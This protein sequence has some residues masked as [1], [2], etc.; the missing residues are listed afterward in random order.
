[1]DAFTLALFSPLIAIPICALIFWL[2]VRRF[3]LNVGKAFDELHWPPVRLVGA[4][5][6]HGIA[7][8]IFFLFYYSSNVAPILV[9]FSVPA[10]LSV[11][12]IVATLMWRI[13]AP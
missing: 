7:L 1:M 4:R 6:S 8:P 12:A 2:T 3:G 9:L 5:I 13:H 11:G 10:G